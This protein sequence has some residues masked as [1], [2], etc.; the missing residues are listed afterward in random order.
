MAKI[1]TKSDKF[2]PFGGLFFIINDF[3]RFVMPHVDSYL[4]LRCR[5]FGYQYS[6]GLLTMACN[7]FSG[8]DRTEDINVVKAKLPQRP[9]FRLCSPDTVLRQL[10]ELAV[11]DVTYTSERGK[12]YSFNTAERL[13]GLLAYTAVKS[14]ALKVGHKYDLDFDHEYLESETWEALPTYKGFRGYGPGCAVLTDTRTGMSTIAGIEN[15]DGNTPVRGRIYTL[16]PAEI[17]TF[18]NAVHDIGAR[19]GSISIC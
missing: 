4:G 7:F 5:L 11:D 19:L 1:I 10:S 17:V 13:N 9:G 16:K 3:K 2:T 12:D 14:N 6:E 18:N 8:G 15:R